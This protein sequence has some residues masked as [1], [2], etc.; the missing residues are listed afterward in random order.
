MY[1]RLYLG[2]HRLKLNF[3]EGVKGFITWTFS[4]ECCR[5]EGGVRCYCLK[6]KCGPIICDPEKVERHLKRMSFI[7]N[8][9]VLTY[10][11]EELP[12]NVPETSN[13][14]AS[15]SRSPMEYEKKFYLTSEMVG[16]AFSVNMTYDEPED[17]DGEGL[18]NEEAQRFY[19]LLNEMN[20]PLFKGLSNS[21]L[22]ICV[23]ILVAKSNSS[24]PD[25]C[26]EF[27]AKMMFDATPTKD[28]LPTC[29][30]DAKKW[31]RS[32]V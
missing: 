32:W 17:F 11:G 6:Y 18:S 14:L 16:D 31:C 1:N 20:T 30:Y 23:I 15:S 21:K 29:F 13:T 9:W 3:E 2:R 27:F 10:N 8:Y 26:L 7:E 24:V 19:Q 4:H 25:Q 12:S 28:N 5:S 22:S